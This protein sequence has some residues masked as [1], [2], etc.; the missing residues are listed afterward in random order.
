MIS[1]K[2]IFDYLEPELDA[3]RDCGLEDTPV[4]IACLDGQQ[5]FRSSARRDVSARPI[6]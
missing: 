6:D 2:R 5:R 4:V 1:L 3:G